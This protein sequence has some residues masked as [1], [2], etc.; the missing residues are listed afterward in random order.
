GALSAIP[1][2]PDVT[3]FREHAIEQNEPH[4]A[5]DVKH[6]DHEHQPGDR[7]RRD[8]SAQNCGID[9]GEALLQELARRSRLLRQTKIAAGNVAAA[10]A[11]LSGQQ[12]HHRQPSPLAEAK[13]FYKLLLRMLEGKRDRVYR[14]NGQRCT[15]AKRLSSK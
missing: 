3:L 4:H 12:S 10:G 1:S 6:H 15:S 13:W 2:L 7:E 11:H 14:G 5:I 9:T 8:Q